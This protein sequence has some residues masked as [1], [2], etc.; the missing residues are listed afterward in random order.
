MLRELWR[1]YVRSK[2]SRVPAR[3]SDQPGGAK[4][5]AAGNPGRAEPGRKKPWKSPPG[6]PS[7]APAPEKPSTPQPEPPA[8]KQLPKTTSLPD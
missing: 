4:R 2:T 5:L 3:V 7:A 1:E 8:G 6:S